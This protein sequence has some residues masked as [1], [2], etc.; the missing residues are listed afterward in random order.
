LGGNSLSSVEDLD[1]LKALPNLKELEVLGTELSE[2]EGYRA[3]VFKKLPGL[4]V[5]PNC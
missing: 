3:D 2:K 5:R 4:E 1:A